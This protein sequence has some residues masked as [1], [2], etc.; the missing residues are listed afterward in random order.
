MIVTSS[1]TIDDVVALLNEAFKLS[2]KTMTALVEHR[3]P[4]TEDLASH[5]T[6]Q[7]AL[8]IDA[9]CEKFK[10]EF[11]QPVCGMLGI[12]NGLFGLNEIGRGAIEA[13]YEE[14]QVLIGFRN[15]HSERP[16]ISHGT[17]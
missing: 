8:A 12:L 13:V 3:V 7:V 17:I 11:K 15:G 10:C 2:P 9:N 16:E 5:P 14:G 4:C 6:I 1:V